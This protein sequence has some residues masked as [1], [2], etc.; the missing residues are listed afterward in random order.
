MATKMLE[1]YNK[2][3]SNVNTLLAVATVLDPRYKI[4]FVRYYYKQ[5]YEDYEIGLEVEKV[6]DVLKDL[7]SEYSLNSGKGKGKEP[8]FNSKL[9]PSGKVSE[10]GR[11]SGF[12]KYLEV[13]ENQVQEKSELEKYF[14]TPNVPLDDDFDILVWWKTNGSTFPILQRIARDILSIHVSSVASESVFSTGGRVLNTHCSRL[15]PSTIE[16]LMCAQ[17]W[18]WTNIK[19]LIIR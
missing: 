5:L 17:N 10:K 15:L 7:T 16:A 11:M 14:E 19:V 3:W 2:Y 18:I 6:K 9:P 12:T 4:P 13:G 8:I 1:K